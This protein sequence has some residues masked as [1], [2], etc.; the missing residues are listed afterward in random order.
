M[1]QLHYSKYKLACTYDCMTLHDK[2]FPFVLCQLA[3]R[4][5]SHDMGAVAHTALVDNDM[6]FVLF[7]HQQVYAF[8]F[9]LSSTLL[10]H[11]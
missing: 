10:L 4:A 1:L 2:Y 5:V 8:A 9:W 11:D 3:V 7:V 6:F